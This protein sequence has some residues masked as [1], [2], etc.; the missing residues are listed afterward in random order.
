MRSA[1]LRLFPP[2][3]TS[4]RCCGVHSLLASALRKRCSPRPWCQR[5]T[6]GSIFKALKQLISNPEGTVNT[7]ASAIPGTSK[8]FMTF[9][10]LKARADG[11]VKAEEME[12]RGRLLSHRFPLQFSTYTCPSCCASHG[13][14]P[15][16]FLLLLCC[17]RAVLT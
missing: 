15:L 11:G 16:F 14:C 9:V 13:A 8:F 17:V 5:P 7:I 4:C 10:L 1:L 3:L 2:L 12:Q 6:S